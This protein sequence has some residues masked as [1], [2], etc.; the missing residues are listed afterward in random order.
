MQSN[1]ERT[2]ITFVE[3]QIIQCDFRVSW[4]DGLNDGL[5]DDSSPSNYDCWVFAGVWC[6][7]VVGS[8]ESLVSLSLTV[9]GESGQSSTD[10]TGKIRTKNS[11]LVLRDWLISPVRDGWE[12]L[13]SWLCDSV[14]SDRGSSFPAGWYSIF[15][16]WSLDILQLMYERGRKSFIRVQ[17]HKWYI[18]T[19]HV[20]VSELLNKTTF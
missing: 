7:A 3:K 4:S 11:R 5:E 19:F 1:Q 12:K 14:L 15:N 20:W 16:R 17:F 18:F 6:L 10:L 9:R 8:Q 13:F 2:D